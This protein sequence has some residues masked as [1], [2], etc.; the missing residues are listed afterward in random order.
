MENKILTKL[1]TKD[2]IGANKNNTVIDW[3]QIENKIITILYENKEYNILIHKINKK[4][5]L[6][7]ISLYKE[8][9]VYYDWELYNIFPNNF[10][11]LKLKNFISKKFYQY[12]EEEQDSYFIDYNKNKEILGITENEIKKISYGSKKKIYIGCNKCGKSYVRAIC[13]VLV[14]G[15]AICD[16]QVVIEGYNDIAT[17]HP[18][19]VKYF[20][21]KN[22]TKQCSYGCNIKKRLCCPNC[23]EEKSMTPNELNLKGFSCKRCSDGISYPNKFMMSMLKQLRIEFTTEYSPKWIKPKR[24]DF[25]IPS[26]KMIIEMDGGWHRKDNTMSGQSKEKSVEIDNY[27]DK[28]AR[29]HGI[30]VVRIDCDYGKELKGHYIKNNI[31]NSELILFKDFKKVNFNDCD[32]FANTSNL[33]L[34]ICNYWNN[35]SNITTTNLINKFNLSQPTISSYLKFGNKIGICNYDPK[36]EMKKN[37]FKNSRAIVKSVI[38]LETNEI[39]ESAIEI[40]KRCYE[41]FGCKMTHRSISNCCNGKQKS[42]YKGFNFRFY[43][44]VSNAIIWL[45]NDNLNKTEVYYHRN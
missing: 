26:K 35:N 28:A 5:R 31:L 6:L 11:N 9:N 1:L 40:E 45:E 25:Y 34:E 17:T 15:C 7:T 10:L 22:D 20:M 38:C 30:E 36:N 18:H 24:Y 23:G 29:E 33:K 12:I 4:D 21:D 8:N 39:F 16:N 19:L 3:T 44:K 13:G 2:G 14:N 42:D 41:L 37:M 43:D 32:I 27:K